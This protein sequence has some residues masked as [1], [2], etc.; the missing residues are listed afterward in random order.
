VKLWAYVAIAAILSG[1]IGYGVHIVKKA[2]RADAAEA[3]AAAAEAGRA[4]DMA[5]VVKRLDADAEARIAFNKRFDDIEAKFAGIKIPPP[6]KLVQQ[7]ETPSVEG[8]CMVPSIGPEFV[9]VWNDST[10]P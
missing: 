5:E 8:K 7:R 4:D 1:A 10:A 2:N 9:R 6:A 3:R